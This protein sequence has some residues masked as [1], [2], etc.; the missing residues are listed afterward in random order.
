MIKNNY[1][2]QAKDILVR[3]CLKY[4]SFLVNIQ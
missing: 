4:F 2:Q 3:N 1:D